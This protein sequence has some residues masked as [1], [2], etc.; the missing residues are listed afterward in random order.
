VLGSA[1]H[2]QRLLPTW[3]FIA[4]HLS[5]AATLS[6]SLLLVALLVACGG[7]S[8]ARAPR[9][10]TYDSAVNPGAHGVG[11]TTLELVDRSRSLEANADFAGADERAIPVEVWYPAE[12]A[13]GSR[14]SRDAP[15]DASDG[16]Y[17]LIVFAHGFS[18]TRVQSIRYTQHLASQGYVVAAPDFPGSNAAAPG[19]PRLSAAVDQ[20]ADVSFVID[21]VLA[22]DA[23]TGHLL[24]AAIDED[25]IGIS[26]HSLGGLTTLLSVYGTRRDTRIKAALPI[27]PASCFLPET[28]VS[29]ENVPVLFIGGSIDRITPIETIRYGYRIA[30]APKYLVELAGGNHIRFSEADLDDVAITDF[31][32]LGF[33]TN[34]FLV[35]AIRLDEK[36]GGNA[37]TCLPA[38]DPPEDT[39]LTLDRQQELLRAFATPFFD[40]YLR[41]SGQALAFLQEDLAGLVPEATLATEVD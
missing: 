31:D 34:E 24:E 27:S 8:T 15:L 32:Q 22:L 11:V 39:P 12:A 41:D 14:E 6:A 26:G 29:D 5:A 20:P 3:R 10:T 4:C 9:A 2:R 37:S 18:G 21:E 28:L 30:S 19:G 16:P 23:T 38:A 1:G 35:D 36:L 25:A 17:P 7:E 13:A 40:A 33:D